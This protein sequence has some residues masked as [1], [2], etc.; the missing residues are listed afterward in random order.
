[1]N[2]LEAKKRLSLN[3][4]KEASIKALQEN[5][6]TAIGYNIGQLYN[7]GEDSEGKKLKRSNKPYSG[8]SK[9]YE[10]KKKKEGKYQGF[11]D[12]HF[13]GKY[14]KGFKLFISG[15]KWG[16][17]AAPAVKGGFDLTEGFREWYKG[18]EG[19]NDRNFKEFKEKHFM[20]TLKK[21]WNFS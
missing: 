8:Y 12:L 18:F 15:N 11:I 1:M 21:L 20:P 5:E 9:E 4:L 2:I 13:I 10:K 3:L 19:L 17:G 14:Y 16:V 6:K 7:A